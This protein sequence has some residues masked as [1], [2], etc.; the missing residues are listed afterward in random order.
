M[1]S[2]SIQIDQRERERERAELANNL[3]L[4]QLMKKIST[5]ILYYNIEPGWINPLIFGLG[6]MGFVGYPN[7]NF[8]NIK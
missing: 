6:W 1:P 4:K 2:E 7:L 8:L 5:S 3:Q